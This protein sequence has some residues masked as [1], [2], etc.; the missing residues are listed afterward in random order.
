MSSGIPKYELIPPSFCIPRVSLIC[1]LTFAG[2]LLPKSNEDLLKLMRWPD[3]FSYFLTTFITSSHSW[4]SALQKK[5]LSS[6]K[7]RW[8]TEGQVRAT[9]IPV[10]FPWFSAWLRR[11]TSASVHRINMKGDKGSLWRKLLP[12]TI[13]SLGSPFM[14]TLYLTEVIHLIIQSIHISENLIFLMTTSMN[15]HSILSYALFISVFM[16]ILLTRP[17]G[18]VLNTWNI[19]WA[20]MILYVICLPA[21]KADW[22]SDIRCGRTFFN[23]WNKTLDIIL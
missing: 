6:A 21:T 10:I 15:D 23:L 11:L 17:P 19:S 7:R 18:L 12:G 5:R 16:V 14:R 4:S 22:V 3:V 9:C 2:T 20:I 13:F 1:C 8:D